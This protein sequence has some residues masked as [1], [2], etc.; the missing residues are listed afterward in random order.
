MHRCVSLS[1]PAS[2]KLEVTSGEFQVSNGEIFLTGVTARISTPEGVNM[3][4]ELASAVDR[5][6]GVMSVDGEGGGCSA[7]GISLDISG[8][9]LFILLLS[10]AESLEKMQ[11]VMVCAEKMIAM[12]DIAGGIA[13]EIKNP[14]STILQASQNIQLRIN[15]M[16]PA[17]I[18]VAE[19]VGLELV[20]MQ[21]YLQARKVDRFVEDIR[22]AALRV[23]NVVQHMLNFGP[24]GAM[25]GEI[26]DLRD[27]TERALDLFVGDAG[28]WKGS[29]FNAIRFVTLFDDA[30]PHVHCVATELEQVVLNLLRNAAH[31]LVGMDPPRDAPCIVLRTFL[32][33]EWV[34]LEVEDNGPG[35]ESD[36]LR[37]IFEPFFTTKPAGLGSGLGLAVSHFIVT[38]GHG[39]RMTVESLPGEGSVFRV[40]LPRLPSSVSDG[41]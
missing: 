15:A 39:G 9:M 5:L 1:M 8:K 33:G 6:R 29:D 17:N 24:R 19:N 23:T 35:M 31:A 13:H 18:T 30:L 40:D 27:V 14:L 22:E 38:K 10:D 21:R 34:R 16:F 2:A 41:V 36:V 26:C 37:H 12:G 20:A 28:R 7:A 4:H 25:K 32:L 3:T 11:D